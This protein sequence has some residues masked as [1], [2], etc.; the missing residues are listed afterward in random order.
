M[1]SITISWL[2]KTIRPYSNNPIKAYQDMLGDLFGKL[3]NIDTYFVE[4][5]SS[6]RIMTNE[7]DVPYSIREGIADIDERILISRLVSYF[8]DELNSSLVSQLRQRMQSEIDASPLSDEFKANL[9]S[10][11]NDYEFIS[12]VALCSIHTD[13]RKRFEH[14]IIDSN[15]LHV[16]LISGD[17]ISTSFNKKLCKSFKITVIPVDDGFTMKLSSKGDDSP[18]ISKD[19]LHGKFIDR[20]DKLGYTSNKIKFNTEYTDKGD[21]FKIGKFIYGQTEFW[22]VPISHLGRRNKAESSIEIITKAIDA[23]IDE[24][25][26]AGQGYPLHMPILGTGRSRVFKTNDEA[27]D[28]ITQRISVKSSY[29]NGT[30]HIVIYKKE[31]KD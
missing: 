9:L 14:T 29:L 5:T 17:L 11:R 10:Y 1:N 21:D 25:D 18:L 28:F 6:S 19:S 12:K 31:I 3:T 15:K 8:K 4:S 30:I 27:I 7:Y 24:Y 13:N 22:L 23:T 16:D 20:M 26:I 2:M